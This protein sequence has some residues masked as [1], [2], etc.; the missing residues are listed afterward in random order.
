MLRRRQ[1][2]GS[3]ALCMTWAVQAQNASAPMTIVVPYAAGGPLDKSARILAE[4]AQAQLG[5][6]QVQNKPG[7]G[8]NLG[9]DTVAKAPKSSKQLSKR[10]TAYKPVLTSKKS[11]SL[12]CTLSS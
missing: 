12:K 4:G 10:S 9:A 11:R 7:A 3:L 2:V 1:L 8:G 6:I 5:P